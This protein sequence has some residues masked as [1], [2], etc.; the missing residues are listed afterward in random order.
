MGVW[1]GMDGGREVDIV[2]VNVLTTELNSKYDPEFG[3]ARRRK[4]IILEVM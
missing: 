2:L 3:D 4:D 1:V